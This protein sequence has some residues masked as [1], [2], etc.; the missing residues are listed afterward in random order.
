MQHLKLQDAYTS[1]GRLGATRSTTSCCWRWG[2]QM[3]RRRLTCLHSTSLWIVHTKG[4]SR[5]MSHMPPS[6]RCTLFRC[7]VSLMD[8]LHFSVCWAGLVHTLFF[9]SQVCYYQ[10]CSACA[11]VNASRLHWPGHCQLCSAQWEDGNHVQHH[12]AACRERN[13]FSLYVGIGMLHDSTCLMQHLA[14]MQQ[15]G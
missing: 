13:C 8:W 10:A 7:A 2:Q 14:V 5:Q 4:P 15:F 11:G 1:V 6:Q 3:Q 9:K 12:P